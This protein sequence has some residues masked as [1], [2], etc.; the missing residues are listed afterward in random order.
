MARIFR[1]WRE[2]MR[3]SKIGNAGRVV[4][5][6][7][8][9]LALT[10]FMQPESSAIRVV[11]NPRTPKAKNAGRVIVPKEVMSISGNGHSDYSFK[12]PSS[13]RVTPDGSLL[14]IENANGCTQVLLFG[15][16]GRFLR[17][18]VKEGKRPGEIGHLAGYFISEKKVVV[19]AKEPD[20]LLWFDSAGKYEREIALPFDVANLIPLAFI[21]GAFYFQLDHFDS[22]SDRDVGFCGEFSII[23]VP[24]DI[25]LFTEG[26]DALKPITSFPTKSF[27]A[28]VGC[29]DLACCGTSRISG[30]MAV[31]YQAKYLALFHTSEYLLKIY[32]PSV[33]TVIREF[34]R[35]YKRVKAKRA[36]AKHEETIGEKTFTLMDNE[37]I[38]GGKICT[39][40][41][42]NYTN[43]IVN[44]LTRG[45][46]VWAVT[47]I[48]DKANGV[49]IDLFS[50][51]GIYEDS[52]Y[53]KLPESALVTLG[54]K[55]ST[56]DGNALYTI[57]YPM[58][59][60]DAC[61]IRKYLIEK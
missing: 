41:D 59:Q 18:L 58:N 3:G 46:E 17:N 32:D 23:D 11:E 53:L 14:L 40:P 29:G 15:K 5:L 30:L 24:S 6:T 21:D 35:S 47:S 4:S 8:L 44:I 38:I 51:S 9:F 22:N 36:R 55:R 39:M 19:L 43:D 20:K 60:D 28:C 13:L 7:A 2:T 12:F 25:F 49:L 48:Y 61:V 56:V 31:P 33:N 57:C 34:R 16:D 27:I 37:M 50:G 42:R 1:Q 54:D 52:F 26:S 45:D 10:C